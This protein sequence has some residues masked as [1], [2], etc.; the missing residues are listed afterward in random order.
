MLA[1]VAR[2]HR[3][4]ILVPLWYSEQQ[5]ED[6]PP[7]VVSGVHLWESSSLQGSLPGQ[8]R[9]RQLYQGPGTRMS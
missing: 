4:Q 5:R 6:G 3:L 7:L 8:E 1:D 2:Q 9:P